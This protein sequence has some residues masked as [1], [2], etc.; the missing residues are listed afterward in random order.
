MKLLSFFI[1][2]ILFMPT[3]ITSVR[4]KFLSAAKSDQ[5]ADELY[6]SLKDVSNDS[7]ETTLVAYK[8]ASLT[9]KAKYEKG[10]L[11]KKKLFTE[12]AKLLE[13]VIKRGADNYEARLIRLS[14]QEN[15]PKITGYNKKIAEDKAF[16]ISNYKRQK[17][18]LKEFTMGFVDNS[19]SFTKE[20]KATFN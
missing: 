13:A 4:E 10:L 1:A 8:A 17:P 14:I 5:A 18:G 9:L 7:A 16:L 19:K 12:G 2:V 6:A 11:S 20:E 3:D 15:A